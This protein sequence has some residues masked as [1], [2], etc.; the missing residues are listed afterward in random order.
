MSGCAFTVWDSSLQVLKA[1]SP[2]LAL[3]GVSTTHC[4]LDTAQYSAVVGKDGPSGISP[5]SKP[6]EVP[7]GIARLA[8][9]PG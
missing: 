6:D 8:L 9:I 7:Y 1:F 4:A 3:C 5:A 2:T